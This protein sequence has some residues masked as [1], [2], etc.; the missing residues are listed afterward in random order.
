MFLMC[1]I[2][3]TKI[4]VRESYVNVRLE[5]T[6]RWVIPNTYELAAFTCIFYTCSYHFLVPKT[7]FYILELYFNFANHSLNTFTVPVQ[8]SYYEPCK[9]VSFSLH[10]GLINH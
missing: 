6:L 10:S 5:F 3:Y 8:Y 2:Y 9:D 4:L 7:L 1:I